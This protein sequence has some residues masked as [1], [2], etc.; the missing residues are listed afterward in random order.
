MIIRTYYTCN[1]AD[2]SQVVPWRAYPIGDCFNAGV[3]Q[4]AISK[5]LK[6]SRETRTPNQRPRGHRQR[7]TSAR[8]DR[9]LMRMVLYNRFHSS[10]RL[11]VEFNRRIEHGILVHIINRRLSTA[12]YPSRRVARCP[13]LT[14]EHRRHCRQWAGWHHDWDLCH[15]RHRVFSDES[16]FKLYHSDG[17]I[18]VLRH[19][20]ER[21]IDACVK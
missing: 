9:I 15:W 12:G 7:S 2:D 17:Q 6:Q 11:R 14:R 18:H 21:Y 1:I 16:R 8:E 13:R 10:P 4:D 5:I 20:R 19:E 3:S